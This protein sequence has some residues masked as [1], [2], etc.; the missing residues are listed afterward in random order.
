[1]ELS[2]GMGLFL[3]SLDLPTP[4]VGM[5]IVDLKMILDADFS[6]P[7]LPEGMVRTWWTEGKDGDHLHIKI[8][9]RDIEIN[10]AGDVVGAGTFLG[11]PA[12]EE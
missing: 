4:E 12:L 3:R 8:D 5:T 2:G 6:P 1:M 9:R 10:E 7:F 11:C